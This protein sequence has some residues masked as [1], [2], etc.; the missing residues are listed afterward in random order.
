MGSALKYSKRQKARNEKRKVRTSVPHK[1]IA[2]SAK[3]ETF[4]KKVDGIVKMWRERRENLEKEE[5]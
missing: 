1:I 5:C 2:I 4:R 3:M